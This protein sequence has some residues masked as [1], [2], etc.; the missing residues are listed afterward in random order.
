M[1][2]AMRTI[3]LIRHAIAEDRE[4]WTGGP[5]VERPL[6][7]KG[8]KQAQV[9][10]THV[11]DVL[12]GDLKG[13][14]LQGIRTSPAM[15]CVDTVAPLAE[16]LGVKLIV[17]KALMEDHAIKLPKDDGKPSV[18]AFC[19]HGDNIPALLR[20]LGVDWQQQCKKGSIWTL[21]L[22]RNDQVKSA[23]YWVP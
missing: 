6:T 7:S 18:H 3:L 20:H 21:Q 8:R 11:S 5:D 9:I 15:R 12:R 23:E 10:A 13:Q 17:D 22:D 1:S 4:T 16:S 2:F 19:A 14:K